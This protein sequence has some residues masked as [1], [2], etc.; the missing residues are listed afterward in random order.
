M[1]IG[2]KSDLNY[3]RKVATKE[4]MDIAKMY[5]SYFMETSA[6][7]KINVEEAFV[8]ITHYLYDNMRAEI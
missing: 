4:G 7:D 8:Q 5:N 6:L 3:E 1:I 2:N